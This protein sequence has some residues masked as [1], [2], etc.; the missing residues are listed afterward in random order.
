MLLSWWALAL[1]EAGGAAAATAGGLG[2]GAGC[3]GLA[4]RARLGIGGLQPCPDG[5][6]VGCPG[7]ALVPRT[8]M[9]LVFLAA[10]VAVV[11]ASVQRRRLGRRP[12]IASDSAQ[13]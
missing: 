9:Q 5:G 11:S 6:G 10:T 13:G 7:D 3:P 8:L 1:E 4:V 2:Q 12:A